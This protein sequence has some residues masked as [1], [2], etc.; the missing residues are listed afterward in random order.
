ME[1]MFKRLKKCLDNHRRKF[2]KEEIES[3]WQKGIIYPDKDSS[4]FRKDITEK[5]I[6]R[7]EYGETTS[8]G[9]EVDHIQPVSKGGGNEID[10]LQPLHWEENRRKSDCATKKPK[11]N[12]I[13]T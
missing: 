5:T 2:T 1:N 6:R 3:V 9:W 11:T 10:N 7:E 4:K 8:Q 12:N 13:M